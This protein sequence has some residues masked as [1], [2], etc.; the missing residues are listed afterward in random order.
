MRRRPTRS[1]ESAECPSVAG[2]VT[3]SWKSLTD[4]ETRHPIVVELRR[5]VDET[6]GERRLS[7]CRRR[8]DEKPWKLAGKETFDRRRRCDGKAAGDCCRRCSSR[9]LICTVTQ[10]GSG[11]AWCSYSGQTATRDRDGHDNQ[12]GGP[13]VVLLWASCWV[14]EQT[15][16]KASHLR[17]VVNWGQ[18]GSPIWTV[19]LCSSERN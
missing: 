2:G 7:G 19:T 3:G 15:P 5:K 6:I 10:V 1:S 17:A 8:C 18:K 4:T 12:V 11:Q 14:R 9:H 13:F 16:R